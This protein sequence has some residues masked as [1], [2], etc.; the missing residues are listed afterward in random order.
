L[1]HA[2]KVS[3]ETKYFNFQVIAGVTNV[4]RFENTSVAQVRRISNIYTPND[5]H[6]DLAICKLN[7]PF[8][9]IY[10]VNGAT[11]TPAGPLPPGKKQFY[12]SPK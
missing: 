9:F 6:V 12:I 2:T 3:R 7:Q 8:Q 1:E 4:I 10:T 11:L 5:T